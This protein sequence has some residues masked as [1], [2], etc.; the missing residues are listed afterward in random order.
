[1]LATLAHVQ[2]AIGNGERVLGRRDVPAAPAA[3]NQR[4]RVEYRPYDEVRKAFEEL[5]RRHARGK[6]VLK[7]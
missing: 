5:E 6:I 2:F 1:M 4:A 3:P 7:P